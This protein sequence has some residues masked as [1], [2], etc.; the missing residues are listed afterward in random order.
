MIALVVSQVPF[1]EK[2]EPITAEQASELNRGLPFLP[3]TADSEVTVTK[4]YHCIAYVYEFERKT[5]NDEP[6]FK[7]SSDVSALAHLKSTRLW[8]NLAQIR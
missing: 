8:K 2:K 5:R 6:V 7:E 1:E 4:D 3:R